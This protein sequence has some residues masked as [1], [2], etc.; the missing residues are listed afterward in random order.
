[1]GDHTKPADE[2]RKLLISGA[3]W[4]WVTTSWESN[5]DTYVLNVEH[6]LWP[7]DELIIGLDQ[8][9][10]SGKFQIAYMDNKLELVTTLLTPAQPVW[11]SF[12]ALI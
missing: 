6:W 1:M 10:A 11:F 4:F 9:T 2:I 5:D 7:I 12:E 3:E 8:L